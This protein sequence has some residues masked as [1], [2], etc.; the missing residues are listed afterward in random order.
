MNQLF[1]EKTYK[2][3]YSVYSKYEGKLNHMPEHV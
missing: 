2:E 3:R 1:K